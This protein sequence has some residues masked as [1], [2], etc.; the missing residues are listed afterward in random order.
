[1]ARD[2]AYGHRSLGLLP[3]QESIS[4]LQCLAEAEP[5]QIERRLAQVRRQRH[6]ASMVL[7]CAVRDHYGPM[8]VG[9][10]GR[11]QRAQGKSST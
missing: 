2:D 6:E 4:S 9:R 11:R 8:R 5:M 10:A 3:A 7:R 1:M